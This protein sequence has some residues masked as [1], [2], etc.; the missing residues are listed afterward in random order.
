MSCRCP[1]TRLPAVVL[2][3]VALA[4]S[5]V[6]PAA[7]ATAAGDDRSG[8]PQPAMVSTLL[9]D[10]L[11]MTGDRLPERVVLYEVGVQG[12]VDADIEVFREVVAAT[13]RDPRGW[14]L[15][16]AVGYVPVQR[17]GDV[18]VWLASPAAVA[19]AHPTC[20]RAYS[21]R[22]EDDVYINAWRWQN[23][24]D[25]FQQRSLDEYRRYVI[26]HEVGHWVGLDH[27]ACRAAGAPAWVMQQ[28]TIS[29][30]GCETRVWPQR[31][32]RVEARRNLLG[33]RPPR[34]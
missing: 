14:S 26:N 10:V 16:D 20:T 7:A 6:A 24:A 13:L 4:L 32:E 2:L 11:G 23:G 5:G 12:E 3:L 17:G 9:A 34:R 8:E 33:A 28:Q 15:D 25:T 1:V 19:A 27:R 30:G 29:L 21:C 31:D 22:V 18:R